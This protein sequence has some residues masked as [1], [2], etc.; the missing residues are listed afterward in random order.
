MIKP[1]LTSYEKGFKIVD[2]SKDV[3]SKLM[4]YICIYDKQI[5]CYYKQSHQRKNSCV[6]RTT[7]INRYERLK[8]S[9]LRCYIEK[10]E[11]LFLHQQK[12]P[13]INGKHLSVHLIESKNINFVHR[14]QKFVKVGK[15][16]F[17]K[18]TIAPLLQQKSLSFKTLTLYR[19]QNI[20]IIK[21]IKRRMRFY[22]KFGII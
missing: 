21:K 17:P 20:E 15:K 7:K 11:R 2:S 1:G 13:C 16:L 6:A 4:D 10:I 12:L 19:Q 18:P 9:D 14:K 8:V 3:I 22:V 5:F